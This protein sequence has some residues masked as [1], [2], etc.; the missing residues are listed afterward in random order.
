MMVWA[1]AISAILGN[2]IP[3][4]SQQQHS[5]K[6]FLVS[7]MCVARHSVVVYLCICHLF[8]SCRAHIFGSYFYC[9]SFCRNIAVYVYE[10]DYWICQISICMYNKLGSSY[11]QKQ[12][13]PHSLASVWVRAPFLQ[14]LPFLLHTFPPFLCIVIGLFYCRLTTSEILFGSPL[15]TCTLGSITR[16]PPPPPP[17][18]SIIRHAILAP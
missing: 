15:H 2:N 17:H 4:G 13:V 8:L 9:F 14:F 6:Q 18:S 3:Y 5:R 11:C 16:P 10:R 1:F 12:L 7:Q